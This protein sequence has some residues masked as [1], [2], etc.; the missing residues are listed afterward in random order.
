MWPLDM[1][2][3]AC[4]DCGEVRVGAFRYCR[5]CGFDYDRTPP[6]DGDATIGRDE[7]DAN[8]V[9]T[10]VPFEIFPSSPNDEAPSSAGD[11]ASF[12]VQALVGAVVLAGIL[13][14]F[15]ALVFFRPLG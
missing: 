11:V 5:I 2:G 4:P 9:T 13:L 14:V 3:H 8:T 1:A 15:M 7:S 12:R 10:F 6:A